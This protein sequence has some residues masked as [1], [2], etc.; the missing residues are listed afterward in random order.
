MAEEFNS[1]AIFRVNATNSVRSYLIILNRPINADHAFYTIWNNSSYRICAD[2]GANRL[3]DALPQDSKQV[4]VC[5]LWLTWSN[6]DTN[7]LE[8]PD[9]ILG[10]LDSLKPEIRVF[11]E[12]LGTPVIEVGDQFS[13][14]FGKCMA[15]L[16]ET[17]A[18]RPQ[19]ELINI[20][21][22]GSISGRVDQGIGLLGELYRE[23][24]SCPKTWRLW[25]VSEGSIS[26]ILPPGKSRLVGLTGKDDSEH[27]R[28]FSQNVGIL[29]IYGPSKITTDGLEWD[30]TDWDT[31]I[32]GNVSSSNHVIADEVLVT[33]TE[34]VLFTIERN[35]ERYTVAA[36]IEQDR[37]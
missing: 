9:T 13:T 22:M 20:V 34:W 8:R 30:V 37:R 29:P 36:A 3:H 11:Y 17:F 31:K 6:V 10:D 19:D 26:W 27:D 15:H 4:Y 14:D 28:L 21:I 1:S 2:G 12:A 33:T 24:Q 23:S 25:L 18:Q 7:V 16:R 35:F 5:S 32:G